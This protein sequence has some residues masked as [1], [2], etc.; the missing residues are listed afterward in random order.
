MNGI[1]MKI[2]EL[3]PIRKF[4]VGE[5]KSKITIKHCA[6]I[7]LE[8]DEQVTFCTKEGKE[9]DIVK[10]NWGYYATP[11]INQRLKSFGYK[12][13]LVKNLNDMLYI[14][15]VD[16]NKIAEFESYLSKESQKIIQWLDD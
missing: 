15:I 6:N 13:A 10:K 8:S 2:D 1:G 5:K 11:S 14:M 3:S 9:Y 4:S 16:E 12:T 7:Y